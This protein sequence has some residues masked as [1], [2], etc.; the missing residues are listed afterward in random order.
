MP[1]G[2]GSSKLG[3]VPGPSIDY[4]GHA[5][6]YPARRQADP[7]IQARVL[8]ALGD[9]QS[10]VNVGAG[11]GSYEPRDRYVLAVEPSAAMRAQRPAWLAPAIDAVAESLPLDDNAVDA[12]MAMATIH[13]WRDPI[14]GLGEMRR[15]ARERVVVLTFDPIALGD[16]WLLRD[17]LP[18]ALADDRQRCPG[19]EKI[20]I[21]L[22][23]SRVEPIPIP[24]DCS[25]G[26]LEAYYA[27][28][29][30]FLDPAV[31][32]AQSVWPRLPKGVEMRAVRALDADLES[33]A[34][35]RR[36]GDLRS[37]PTYAG[38]LRL[39]VANPIQALTS[40]IETQP[41]CQP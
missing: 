3:Q 37:C 34:W 36:Y 13:H 29:E 23:E 19:I 24:V 41:E 1:A 4:D 25:D 15:V 2:F 40:R 6:G 38:A 22:G 9:A 35:D 11:P 12:A 30:A 5:A 32:S 18:E 33:G 27:R 8:A 16:F 17:Y 26:F 39:I 31:R 10:V 20:R 14:R 21:A 28:P 7:C